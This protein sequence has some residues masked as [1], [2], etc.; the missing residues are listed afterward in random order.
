M[1][2]GPGGGPRKVSTGGMSALT[3]EEEEEESSANV[4]KAG[5]SPPPAAA[6]A[7]PASDGKPSGPRMV[8]H[9]FSDRDGIIWC[10][11]CEGDLIVI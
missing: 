2:V 3:V 4:T 5:C 8:T 7:T 11:C 9:Q 10:P 1:E 6:G